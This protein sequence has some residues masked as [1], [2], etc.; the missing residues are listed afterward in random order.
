MFFFFVF[1]SNFTSTLVNGWTRLIKY[2]T[3]IYDRLSSNTYRPVHVSFISKLTSV[4]IK[5]SCACAYDA[6]HSHVHPIKNFKVCCSQS[7]TCDLQ[8][9]FCNNFKSSINQ[10]ETDKIDKL[11]T[12]WVVRKKGNK[13]CVLVRF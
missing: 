7:G 6:R 5:W 2:T 1:T 11:H 4:K 10:I 12:Y 3:D 9:F 8:Y 13:T